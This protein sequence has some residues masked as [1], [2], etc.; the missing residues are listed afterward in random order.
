MDPVKKECRDNKDER[1][2][3]RDNVT[4]HYDAL[5]DD[6]FAA[7]TCTIESMLPTLT[8]TEVVGVIMAHYH[9]KES[10]LEAVTV[11]LGS[12][13]RTKT[14]IL[15]IDDA[16]MEDEHKVKIYCLRS[17]NASSQTPSKKLGLSHVLKTT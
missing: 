8:P 10:F 2:H 16:F 1:S 17:G 9:Y 15:S 14:D 5:T 13:C 4:C 7:T 3:H 6:K 12:F 11:D